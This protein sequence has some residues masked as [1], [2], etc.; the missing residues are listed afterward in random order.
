MPLNEAK[1]RIVVGFLLA[2]AGIVVFAVGLLLTSGHGW[3]W[4][5]DLAAANLGLILLAGGCAIAAS[6][7]T[8]PNTAPGLRASAGLAIAA[9]A[10][11]LLQ[12]LIG[13]EHSVSRLLFWISPLAL[14]VAATAC[15]GLSMAWLAYDLDLM[16]GRRKN[17]LGF[18]GLL[19]VLTVLEAFVRF[20]NGGV[21]F[22]TVDLVRLSTIGLNAIQVFFLL[23][24]V[25][26]V[27]LR[28]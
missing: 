10:V 4:R 14:Y 18:V 3:P 17:G 9:F 25:R 6:A 7:A 20:M 28:G 22:E 8:P 21:E 26:V 11:N 5:V 27:R 16:K 2:A 15:L 24:L 19:F 13:Q 1:N 12:R 23:L